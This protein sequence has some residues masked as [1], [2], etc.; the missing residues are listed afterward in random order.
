MTAAA[1][2]RRATVH[3]GWFIVAAGTLCIFAGLGLGR[4]AL[5]MLLPSMGA[6]L[7]LSYS[8]MGLIGTCNFT[9]Y[10]LAVIAS[11]SL[12]ARL[13]S[14][15]LVFFALLLVAFSM[16]LVA[17]AQSFVAV[18]FFYMLTGLGSGASNV[19]MMGLVSAWFTSRYRG[20]AAGFIV[21]GSGFA[22]LVSGWLIPMLNRLHGSDGWRWNWMVLGGIVFIIA[23]IC[24]AVLRD[25]PAELGLLPL[26][27]EAA[28]V[29]AAGV[30]LSI[31][32]RPIDKKAIA[33]LA[34]IYF[35]FGYTYV[36]Y[37][38]FI[39]TCLVQEKGFSEMTAGG[40]WSGIGL[41][42]LFSGPVFGILS[43]RKGRTTALVTV[44]T[45]QTVAYLLI[46]LPLP[47]PFLYLSIGCYGFVAW[48]IPS[49]MAALVGDYA[50]ANRAV[51]VFGFIT[52]IFGLGQIAGPYV[53]G[54]LAELTGSFATS[55][56]MAAFFAAAAVA[57]SALLKKP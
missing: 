21:I 29:A 36:I 8:Q 56:L 22:I 38:T 51:R 57:A 11:G 10:L 33:H 24:L 54:I 35:L 47:R 25:R 16:L 26:G 32:E 2:K 41:L 13:G 7:K 52:F 49:I 4:F 6:A 39:V 45:V 14:R 23:F 44:F 43:D 34:F 55:F 20:R 48:S 28:P 1:E 53:A 12:A 30:T 5:G 46:A 15:R 17:W 37:A 27:W 42:S 3:Y 19:P 31:G 40:L 9:G 50:G 18:L